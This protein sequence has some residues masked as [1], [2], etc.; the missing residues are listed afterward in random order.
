[1]RS[2]KNQP[3]A[4]SAN[5]AC[6]R[7]Q[8]PLEAKDERRQCFAW[9]ARGWSSHTNQKLRL[10]KRLLREFFS[11]CFFD[12]DIF[13]WSCALPARKMTVQNNHRRFHMTLEQGLKQAKMFKGHLDPLH[14]FFKGHHNFSRA[15]IWA[16]DRQI[17]G[18][19]NFLKA[20]IKTGVLS[21]SIH[22]IIFL[23]KLCFGKGTIR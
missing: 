18:P 9:S 23:C 1:M 22:I 4:R 19:S 20:K 10:G 5:I 3:Q 15:L 7:R 13:F 8:S 2:V 12:I 21:I 16:L 11:Y 14:E 6:W 17:L